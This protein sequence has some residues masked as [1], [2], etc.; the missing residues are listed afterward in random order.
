MNRYSCTLSGQCV[1]NTIGR[2]QTQAR[3]QASCQ[4]IDLNADERE[5]MFIALSYDPDQ[6]LLLAPG[7][8][9]EYLVREYGIRSTNDTATAILI[10]LYSNDYLILYVGG[11]MRYLNS[12][13]NRK[14]PIPLDWFD[15]MLLRILALNPTAVVGRINWDFIRASSLIGT[16]IILDTLIDEE[17]IPKVLRDIYNTV[18]KF[19]SKSYKVEPVSLR[20]DQAPPAFMNDYI[21]DLRTRFITQA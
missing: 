16:S 5:M 21:A 15:F 12:E 9:V 1:P 3:C 13:L 8:Q 20:P 2:H 17:D 14:P 18:N 6:A 4:P 11:F 10:A 19:V 7:D